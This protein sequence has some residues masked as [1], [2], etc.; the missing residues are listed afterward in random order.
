MIDLNG[1]KRTCMKTIQISYKIRLHINS[2]C[3]HIK[4]WTYAKDDSGQFL[5]YF[6]TLSTMLNV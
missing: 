3:I 1:G 4:R 2:D 5:S 6:K